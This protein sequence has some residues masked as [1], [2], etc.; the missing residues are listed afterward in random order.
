MIKKKYESWAFWIVHDKVKTSLENR[1]CRVFKFK[2][3]KLAR[4]GSKNW[5]IFNSCAAKGSGAFI[6]MIEMHFKAHFE[7][8]EIPLVLTKL[9]PFL[10]DG[11][12]SIK[13]FKIQ[14]SGSRS[15]SRYHNDRLR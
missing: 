9:T 4:L 6:F 5:S 15:L 2:S 3:L 7:K 12:R 8:P 10:H 1:V 14:V 13:V 11:P